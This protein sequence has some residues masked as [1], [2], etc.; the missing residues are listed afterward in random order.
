MRKNLSGKTDW[1]AHT[2]NSAW[3][4]RGVNK[5]ERQAPLPDQDEPAFRHKK[6]AK[7]V[8]KPWKIHMK[9]SR[10]GRFGHGWMLFGSYE[11]QKQRDEALARMQSGKRLWAE[12]KAVDPPA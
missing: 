12:Y 1:V 11:T 6:K 9:F 7:K 5:R 8:K 4:K 2:R 3:G 10:F